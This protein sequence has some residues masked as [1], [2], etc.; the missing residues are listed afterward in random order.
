MIG[1]SIVSQLNIYSVLFFINVYI[2]DYPDPRLSRLFSLVL[3]SAGNRG[4]SVYVIFS[5]LLKMAATT[6]ELKITC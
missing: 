4:S 6:G 5:M 3:M 2:F 1:I